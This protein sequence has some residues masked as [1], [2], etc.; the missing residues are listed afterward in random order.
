MYLEEGMDPGL[1]RDDGV[2]FLDAGIPAGES[3]SR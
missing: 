3:S 1:R 2:F